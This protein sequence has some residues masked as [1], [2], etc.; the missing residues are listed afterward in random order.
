M[1]TASGQKLKSKI[2]LLLAAGKYNVS[3]IVAFPAALGLGAEK[4]I[5][6]RMQILRLLESSNLIEK[7][8]CLSLV[9]K[10]TDGKF[11][12]RFIRPYCDE[13]GEERITRR[14]LLRAEKDESGRTG[15]Q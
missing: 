9:L 3:S 13:I 5:E 1:F 4:R 11:V 6:P 10:L 7:W 8:P 15:V 14:W 2:E 12:E